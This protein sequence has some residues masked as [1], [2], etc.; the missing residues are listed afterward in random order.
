MQLITDRTWGKPPLQ[1]SKQL[2]PNKSQSY[3]TWSEKS[4]LIKTLQKMGR[5]YHC[6]HIMSSLLEVRHDSRHERYQRNARHSND[7]SQSKIKDGW[8]IKSHWVI[9][10]G[11]KKEIFCRGVFLEACLLERVNFNNVSLT[12]DSRNQAQSESQL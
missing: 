8:L 7:C 6:S 4:H 10:V 11:S 3:Q 12:T 9:W 2:D 1:V 5:Y